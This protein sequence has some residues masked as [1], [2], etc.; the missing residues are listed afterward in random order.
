MKLIYRSS[1]FYWFR[2]RR[3]KCPE[4]LGLIAYTSREPRK[5]LSLGVACL[6]DST[7][8]YKRYTFSWLQK[9]RII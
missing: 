8:V 5:V 1:H 9:A 2:V 4:T 7:K 6:L 3:E